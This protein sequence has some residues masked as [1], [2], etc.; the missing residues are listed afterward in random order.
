M[1]QPIFLKILR[2]ILVMTHDYKKC[3]NAYGLIYMG[4]ILNIK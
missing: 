4:L 1:N 3:S 2:I